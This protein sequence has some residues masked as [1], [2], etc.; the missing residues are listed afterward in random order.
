MTF[1]LDPDLSV[2]KMHWHTTAVTKSSTSFGWGKGDKS[3]WCRVAGNT[4]WSHMVPYVISC[5][6][7]VIST[8]CYTRL[9]YFTS[10][11][12]F[13][14]QG[15]KRPNRQMW[16][17]ALQ[18]T[19]SGNNLTSTSLSSTHLCCIICRAWPTSCDSLLSSLTRRIKCRRLK[20]SSRS[21]ST[22]V[23]CVF[24]LLKSN[25]KQHQI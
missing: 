11:T 10:Q 12:K 2:L 20:S 17:N 5:S 14:G 18:P 8:N 13:L 6:G 24:N 21:K 7:E 25:C 9:L 1:I 23:E 4:V 16:P 3:H 15:F 22:R 19:F